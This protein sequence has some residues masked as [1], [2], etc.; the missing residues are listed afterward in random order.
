MSSIVFSST[1]TIASRLSMSRLIILEAEWRIC[2]SE[3]SLQAAD[4]PT[5]SNSV[6]FKI[7]FDFA[8]AA[9]RLEKVS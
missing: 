1:L 6:T 3:I 7:D 2:S 8:A 4:M 9:I 5:C